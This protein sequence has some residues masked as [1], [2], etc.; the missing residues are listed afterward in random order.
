MTPPDLDPVFSG[1]LSR[2]DFLRLGAVGLGLF[3]PFAH[4]PSRHWPWSLPR[5]L[6]PRSAVQQALEA[7]TINPGQ[8]GRVLD[9][10]I[11]VYD[12]PTFSAQ[13]V[14]T[15]WR[16]RVIPITQATIG[17]LEDLHNPVWYRIGEEGYAH[18]GTIQPV[19]TLP[20]LP[21]S[22]LPEGGAL[23]EVTVPFTDARLQPGNS[24]R[25]AYRYYYGTTHWVIGLQSLPNGETWYRVLDDK[26][27]YLYSVPAAHLRIL[28]ADDLAPL[29]PDIPAIF[30]HIQVHIPDQVLIAYEADEPVFVTRVAT[31]A[32]FS[33]GDFSTP[34]GRFI[35]FHKRGSRHMA[36]GNLAA[37]GYD[38]PGVP[39]NCYITEEGIAF[40]GTY[41]HNNFGRPRSHGCI[42]LTTQAANWL[43]RWTMPA[44]PPSDQYSYQQF[45]TYV[46]I[47]E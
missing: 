11:N 41:W 40:H 28:S 42:N 5:N 13:R 1:S 47:I 8:Q 45:G 33:N 10:F 38:L 3:L 2:R 16:D 29:S 23:A 14:N 17:N 7:Q 27:E 32:V 43:Y 22:N 19:L 34:P 39:W 21:V 25:V 26:W 37:N 24:Q 4:R 35:T 15:Y 44:V 6:S 36:A 12:R 9:S 18:S 20:N 30:K 46:D 31:G